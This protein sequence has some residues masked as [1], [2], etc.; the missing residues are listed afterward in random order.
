MKIPVVITKLARNNRRL[1][2]T[3]ER[4]GPFAAK[5]KWTEGFDSVAKYQIGQE[6]EVQI[7]EGIFST[8]AKEPETLVIQHSL[9]DGWTIRTIND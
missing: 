5:F 9:P 4:L 2:I 3:A 8:K 6:I 1:V 7:S